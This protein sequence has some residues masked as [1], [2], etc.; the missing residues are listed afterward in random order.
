MPSRSSKLPVWR[1]LE[2]S[3]PLA[4]RR[5]AKNSQGRGFRDE[6][7]N[8]V[9]LLGIERIALRAKGLAEGHGDGPGISGGNFVDLGV[10]G[11]FR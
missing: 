9:D 10:P 1:E 11:L 2:L 8:I 7:L 6:D 4:K 5:K 3:S